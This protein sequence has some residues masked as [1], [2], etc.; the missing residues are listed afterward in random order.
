[1]A[2][3][4]RFTV[5]GTSTMRILNRDEG[6]ERDRYRLKTNSL[7][8]SFSLIIRDLSPVSLLS[9]LNDRSLRSGFMFQVPGISNR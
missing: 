6:D 3:K 9:L 4:S 2:S 8:I 7:S 5:Y 1:M